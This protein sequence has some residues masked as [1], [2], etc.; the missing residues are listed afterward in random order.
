MLAWLNP[1]NGDSIFLHNIRLYIVTFQKIVL[2]N[3]MLIFYTYFCG[4]HLLILNAVAACRGVAH[5]FLWQSWL[6]PKEK[7]DS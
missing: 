7:P 4:L 2:F 6:E 3:I 5:V 1:G